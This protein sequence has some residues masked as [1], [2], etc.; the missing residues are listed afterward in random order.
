MKRNAFLNSRIR[1]TSILLGFVFLFLFFFS[2]SL[3][4]SKAAINETINF[5]G[6]LV[7]QSDGTNFT[8]ACSTSCDF[9]FRIY[10][11]SSGG[12][13]LWEETQS[14]VTINDGIFNVALGSSTP[15]DDAAFPSMSFDRDD[16]YFQIE[17]DADGAGGTYEEVFDSPRIRFTAVPYAMHALTAENIAGINSNGFVQIAPSSTQTTGDTTSTIIDINEDGSNTPDLLNLAVAGSSRFTISNDGSIDINTLASTGDG[18]NLDTSSITTGDGFQ[19]TFDSSNLTSGFAF[20]IDDNGTNRFT[21]GDSGAL[22]WLGGSGVNATLTTGSATDLV[23]IL[24]GNLKVGDG[25]PSVALN[26]EDAYIEGTFEVDG[27]SDFGDNVDFNNNQLIE[28]RIENLASAPTCDA[29]SQGRIYHNTTANLSYICN[30][31]SWNQIESPSVVLAQYY[32][33]SGG[34]DLNIGTPTLI[35]WDSEAREDV[36]ITHDTAVNNSRV[37]LDEAGWYRLDYNIGIENQDTGGGSTLIDIRCRVRL[38]GSTYLTPGTS[39]SFAPGGN[40]NP[41]EMSNTGNLIFQTSSSN[42]YYEILCDGVGQ[43]INSTSALTIAGESWIITEKIDGTTAT[44]TSTVD[45][46]AVYANDSDKI[47][48]V[49]D[50]AGLEFLSSSTGNI[51]FDLQS[52]GDFILQDNNT[53]FLTIDDSGGF[54]YT[55]DATD[56]PSFVLNNLGSGS[57]RVNDVASDTTPFIIDADGNVGIGELTP[58]AVLEVVGDSRFG[59]GTNYGSFDGDGDLLFSG[60]ADYLVEDDDYAFR[61]QTDEDAGLLFNATDGEFQFLD[62]AASSIFEI[63][64]L[65]GVNA[66]IITAPNLTNCDILYTDATGQFQCGTDEG[67]VFDVYDN[68]GGQNFTT[69]ITINLDTIRRDQAN[70]SLAADVITV[71]SDGTYNITYTCSSTATQNN[72]T[73]SSCWIERDTGGGF[74]EVDGSRCYAYHRVTATGDD[75]CTRSIIEDLSAGDDFRLR[76]E[77]FTGGAVLSTL[78]D[79]SSMTFQKLIAPGADLAEI[80]YTNDENIEAGDVVSIDPAL[81]AGVKK[82]DYKDGSSILGIISTQP[83]QVIGHEKKESQGRPVLLALTGRVPVKMD[84]ESEP[85][86]PGDFISVSD[87]LLG[88]GKKATQNGIT[89]GKALESWE[90]KPEDPRDTVMVFVGVNSSQVQNSLLDIDSNSFNN[91]NTFD[92]SDSDLELLSEMIIGSNTMN[93]TNSHLRIASLEISNDAWFNGSVVIKN[94]VTFGSDSVG[95]AIIAKGDR[96]VEVDFEERYEKPPIIT[97]TLVDESPVRYYLDDVGSR[98]FTIKINAST[99]KDLLFNWHSFSSISDSPSVSKSYGDN[100]NNNNNNGDTND[101]IVITPS[102]TPTSTPTPSLSPSPTPIA[103]PTPQ[104]DETTDELAQEPTIPIEEQPTSLENASQEPEENDTN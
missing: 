88:Y 42:E 25:S 15:F 66:G 1:N 64:A 30:G 27:T 7:D 87:S 9:R 37:T 3:H 57:F 98:G 52:T 63:G 92:Y 36:G 5:Q 20:R 18:F 44:S 10:D 21:I 53:T 28:A 65:N 29:P 95:Q 38:N 91:S 56:N 74:T 60:T 54:D 16:L 86:E 69:A 19:L 22:A 85:I 93:F 51:S 13:L 11:A 90:F 67:A 33:N 50:G 24:T 46:D 32:D 17:I 104:P 75:S 8:G 72:R 80:Y 78:A 31:T 49:S 35:G 99:N 82:A 61:S 6:K 48:G 97:L 73:G 4:T 41:S 103:S 84:P 26:G 12:S 89:I 76:T 55:L 2:T 34:T 77:Q 45:L 59:D 83:G 102:P 96:E 70:Y 79:G 43:G 71:N 23:N 68:T 58:A 40:G 94:H 47:L 62:T 100:N 39:Y 81:Y 14:S 101:Q